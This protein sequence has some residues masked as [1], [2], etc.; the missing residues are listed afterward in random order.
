MEQPGVQGPEYLSGGAG[1][2]LKS[3]SLPKIDTWRGRGT[4]LGRRYW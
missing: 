2:A 4:D 1:Q 3:L